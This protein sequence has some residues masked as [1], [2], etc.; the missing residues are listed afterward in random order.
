MAKCVIFAEGTSN[1]TN[2]NLRT[3]FGKLFGQAQRLNPEIKMSND[4]SG[5]IKRFLSEINDPNSAYKKV[6]LLID[7]DGPE[8]TRSAWLAEH[9]LTQ[10]QEQIFFM[11]QE[12]EAWFIAQSKVL[13][14]YYPSR[15]HELLG[16]SATAI[17]KPSNELA[18]RTKNY[19]VKGT[20]AKVRDGAQLLIK[21]DLPKL[22]ADF[23]D[24]ARLIAAL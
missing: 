15:K 1:T 23:P 24:V 9:K 11:V 16:K 8:A 10:Y 7:L 3:A 12:M 6:L 4:K 22:Q 18:K 20:Y 13:K 17:A 2:G 5:T 19:P 21:L 14:E